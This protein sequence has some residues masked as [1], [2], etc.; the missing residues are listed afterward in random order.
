MSK[1]LVFDDA[2]L[3]S[4]LVYPMSDFTVPDDDAEPFFVAAC[5]VPGCPWNSYATDN[6]VHMA[7]AYAIND[8]EVH[9]DRHARTET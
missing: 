3:Q 8:A 6:T 1:I 9:L 7:E 5:R 4:V 2:E